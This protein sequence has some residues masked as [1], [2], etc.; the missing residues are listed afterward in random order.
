M[1]HIIPPYIF[2]RAAGYV[3][4]RWGKNTPATADALARFEETVGF[5]GGGNMMRG[6]YWADPNAMSERAMDSNA[7][8]DQ[9]VLP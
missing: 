1:K 9:I 4:T 5:I 2:A 6:R 7:S 8:D 3:S